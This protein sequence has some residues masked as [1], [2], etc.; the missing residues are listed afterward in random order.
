MVTDFFS[1]SIPCRFCHRT[2]SSISQDMPALN[3]STFRRLSVYF[4]GNPFGISRQV[5]R[6]V[7]LWFLV[8]GGAPADSG[9]E[10]FIVDDRGLEYRRVVTR[11]HQ[12]R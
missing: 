6:A 1:I 4:F 5:T 8:F 2:S 12:H 7:A 10:L 3:S 9:P 11:F